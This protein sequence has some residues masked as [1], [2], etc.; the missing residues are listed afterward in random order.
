MT[1]ADDAEIERA[2]RLGDSARVRVEVRRSSL[3]LRD[4][5]GDT[6][7]VPRMRIKCVDDLSKPIKRDTVAVRWVMSYVCG[8]AVGLA[9]GAALIEIV[10]LLTK[11]RLSP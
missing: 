7:P 10:S 9:G 5:G 8:G 3:A 6:K 1:L 2:G 11:P 4:L